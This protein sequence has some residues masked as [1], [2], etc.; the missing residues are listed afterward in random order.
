MEFYIMNCATLI[1]KNIAEFN[2]KNIESNSIVIQFKNS[3]AQHRVEYNSC[4]DE[5]AN[6]NVVSSSCSYL[7]D[8][9]FITKNV[10]AKNL[11]LSNID[12]QFVLENEK[13]SQEIEATLKKLETLIPTAWNMAL[14]SF[15]SINSFEN[16]NIT[17]EISTMATY[18]NMIIFGI[19]K[20]DNGSEI[21]FNVSGF[22][23][24]FI[25]KIKNDKSIS[26][27]L[28]FKQVEHCDVEDDDF[29]YLHELEYN[30]IIICDDDN[31]TNDWLRDHLISALNQFQVVFLKKQK[32]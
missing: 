22:K 20:L 21:S 30:N 25:K 31:L 24:N 8:K 27:Y 29:I 26:F 4:L 16:S 18:P 5:D 9:L 2:A 6:V 11:N 14:K 12:N 1:E 17:Y 13:F 10:K 7:D 28:E 19:Q 32:Q 15:G 23:F 3:Y